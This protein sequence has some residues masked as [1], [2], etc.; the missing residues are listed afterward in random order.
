MSLEYDKRNNRYRFHFDKIIEGQRVRTSK[1]LPKAWNRAACERYDAKETARL[2]DSVKNPKKNRV[3]IQR[4]VDLYCEYRCPELKNGHGAIAELARI[5][6]WYDG[7]YL[8]ELQEVARDYMSD[9]RDEPEAERPS[10][11]TIRNKLS[12]LRAACTYARKHHGIGDPHTSYEIPVP[13]V[14]NKRELYLSR[15]QMLQIARR[16][17]D[18][19]ARAVLRVCFYSGMRIGEVMTIGVTGKILEDGYYLPTTKNNESRI[20]PLHPRLRVLNKYFPLK[21]SK[22]WIQRLIRSAMDAEGFHDYVLHDVR[23]STASALINAGV[24]LFTVG[25][26]LGHKDPSS[27]KRYAHLKTT[28]LNEA[29]LKIK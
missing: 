21:W 15:A 12:Y 19:T 29:I 4:A 8:D 17:D 5:F 18:R 26:V 11:A 23:H 24:D 20:A 25:G 9:M 6:D 14:K 7:R 3:L 16:I 2:Y 10:P 28:T 27:T 1:L 22:I 13:E